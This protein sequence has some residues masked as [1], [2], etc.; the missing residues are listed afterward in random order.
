M[1]ILVA[2]KTW[3]VAANSVRDRD[4]QG[5]RYLRGINHACHASF[6][7]AYS[8]TEEPH[9]ICIIDSESKNVVVWSITCSSNSAAPESCSIG[10]G[11]TWGVKGGLGDRMNWRVELKFNAGSNSCSNRIWRECERIVLA[12]CYCLHSRSGGGCRGCRF[13]RGGCRATLGSS[14]ILREGP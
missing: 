6:T 3:V 4:G 2:I 9:W 11:R 7:M 12:N 13:C 1:A 14:A 5:T 8:C 10:K